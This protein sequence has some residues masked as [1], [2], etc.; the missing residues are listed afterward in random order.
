MGN[1]AAREVEFRPA[2][3][4]TVDG[5]RSLEVAD[6]LPLGPVPKL[7]DLCLARLS[8]YPERAL[9]E[10]HLSPHNFNSHLLH[11]RVIRQA[12]S[13]IV[14]TI[15]F[16]SE[17]SHGRRHMTREFHRLRR[18][19][20]RGEAH[21]LGSFSA[22]GDGPFS[23]LV[24]HLRE[25]IAIRSSTRWND[26]EY[27]LGCVTVRSN[28]RWNETAY[29]LRVVTTI[30]L[31]Q[32]GLSDVLEAA[33]SEQSML[34]HV[35]GYAR[36]RH[37]KLIVGI[38]AIVRCE[39]QFEAPG[40]RSF[41]SPQPGHWQGGRYESRVDFCKLNR[42]ELCTIMQQMAHASFPLNQRVAA[43]RRVYRVLS[44]LE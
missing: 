7:Q 40:N 36:G 8:P 26:A 3:P 38:G 31:G 23:P 30:P 4:S 33:T 25:D 17:K 21:L 20:P 27:R 39:L 16:P 34:T 9:R 37:S 29:M 13:E 42:K 14:F 6:L 15:R 41:S 28:T 32:L 5:G 2:S 24:A 44:A 18:V 43:K 35:H 22:R 12:R 1:C 11:R 19:L 10:R